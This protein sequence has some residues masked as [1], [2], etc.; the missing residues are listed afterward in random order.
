MLLGQESGIT[1]AAMASR[2][3]DSDSHL[4]Q[5]VFATTQWSVVLSA[6]QDA[7]P[8]AREALAQLCRTYWSPLY[9]YARRRVDDV[10]EAQDLTQAFFAELLDKNYVGQAMPERGR[11]RAFL[12]TA[13]K[14]F[15]GR[16]WEKRKAQKRGGGRMPIPLDFATVDSAIRI[17]PS[18]GLTPEQL[19][20]REWATS[21]LARILQTLKAEFAQAG[22]SE[23]FAV[24]KEF[25]IG[26]RSGK[27]Y[28]QAAAELQ[29]SESA[30]RKTASRMRQRLRQLLRAE[31]AET[32]SASEDVEDEI[33][34]LFAALQL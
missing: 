2:T 23:Q 16:Q 8:D 4:R 24:L 21:L 15:L 5:R 34:K 17:E 7:S 28:A 6:G 32:V 9:A 10:H 14:H 19:F 22:K 33:Q 20:D 27:R 11:F 29:M 1:L 13:F 18:G 25:L 26:E 3:S 30:A 31:I 12:I